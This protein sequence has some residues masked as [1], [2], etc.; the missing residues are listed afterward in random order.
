VPCFEG[1]P[2]GKVKKTSCPIYIIDEQ[3]GTD[4]ILDDSFKLKS[5]V[6]FPLYACA[7]RVAN[8]YA[9]YLEPLG[10]TYTQYITML[11]LWEEEEITIKDLCLKLYLDSG[12][13]TPV[14]KKLINDGYII[15]HRSVSDERVVVVS[16]TDEGRKLYDKVKD[17][18][19]QVCGALNEKGYEISDEKLSVLRDLLY[20]I[21]KFC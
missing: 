20:E 18:P 16:L 13:I 19:K 4:M 11:I 1:F 14:I 10:L 12:T 8:N 6:C 7:R 15:K 17:V 3:S 2:S 21:L 5:Q 9:P